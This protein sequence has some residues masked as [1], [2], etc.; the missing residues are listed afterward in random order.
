MK[1]RELKG[2]LN[3]MDQEADVRVLVAP[4][5]GHEHRVVVGEVMQ[6]ESFHDRA[7]KTHYVNI[8]CTQPGM[9]RR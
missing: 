9:M 7:E 2:L 1:V 6:L 4:R 3:T 8:R 5:S